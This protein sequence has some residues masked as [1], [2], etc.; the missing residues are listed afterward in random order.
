[1]ATNIRDPEALRMKLYFRICKCRGKN[2]LAV[3][4]LTVGYLYYVI[5]LKEVL[6]LPIIKQLVTNCYGFISL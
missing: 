5:L 3:K 6:F 2:Q 4:P 1:M